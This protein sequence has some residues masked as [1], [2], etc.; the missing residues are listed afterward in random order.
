MSAKKTASTTEKTSQIER[1]K[2][3]ARALGCDEDK[4][5]FEAALG[6]VAA[7]K[8]AIAAKKKRPAKKR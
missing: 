1:F 2:E 5:R 4:E 8:P 7:H 3:T 6:K